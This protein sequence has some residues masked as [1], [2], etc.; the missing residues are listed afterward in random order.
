MSNA[1]VVYPDLTNMFVQDERSC[2]SD[3][4]TGDIFK[5]VPKD[6]STFRVWK[7]EVLYSYFIDKL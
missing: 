7:I 2:R 4:S 1:T 5:N 3:D 6:S